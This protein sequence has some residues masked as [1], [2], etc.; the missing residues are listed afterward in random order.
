VIVEAERL[1]VSGELA[2]DAIHTPGGFIDHVVILDKLSDEF[3]YCC[4]KN[5]RKAPYTAGGYTRVLIFFSWLCRHDE[6][7]R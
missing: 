1:A 6:E 2:P 3:G 5:R 7:L 4:R